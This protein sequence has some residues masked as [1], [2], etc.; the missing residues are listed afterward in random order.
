MIGTQ[1]VDGNG[2]DFCNVPGFDLAFDSTAAK[3]NLST[4]ET[5]NPGP[6]PERATYR[7]AWSDKFVH[8]YIEV[9]DPSVNP[10]NNP[11]DIWN[12]DS[13]EFMISTSR[14]VTGLTS[15]DAN[16]LHVIANSVIGVTVKGTGNS[17]AHTQI[18]DPNL[19]KTHT[20][21]TGYAVELKMPWPGGQTVASGASIYFDA[22]L[23]GARSSSSGRVA[24]ALLFQGPTPA[25]TTCTGTGNDIAPFCD[26]RMWCPTK[27]Q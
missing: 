16:T 17:G 22:A 1:V 24:Q 21:A 27:F 10:N 11:A 2:D 6:R 15:T 14:E 3:I 7:L 13:V 8:V 5:A 19:F 4:E 26:D 20:T 23:N 18:G 12:G 9:A 25:S